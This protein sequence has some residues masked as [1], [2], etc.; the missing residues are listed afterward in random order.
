[1]ITD[2]ANNLFIGCGD[3]ME[4]IKTDRDNAP[5]LSVEYVSIFLKMA[6]K[7][8]LDPQ[9]LL[10]EAGIKKEILKEKEA[11]ITIS[12]YKSLIGNKKIFDYDPAF[13][14]HVGQNCD[15]VSH[16]ILGY[17]AISSPNLWTALHLI[18]KYFKIRNRMITSNF[19]INDQ[20]VVIKIESLLDLGSSYPFTIESILSTLYGGMS[21]LLGDKM[22]EVSIHVRYPEPSY[23][24]VYKEI[25]NTDVSFEQPC[26]QV[27]FSAQTL[28]QPFPMANSTLSKIAIQQ[29][30]AM[31]SSLADSKDLSAHIRQILLKT[32]ERF[33]S[34]DV[35]ANIL[36]MTPRTLRRQL[37]K[38]NTTYQ[39]I[40][41]KVRKELALQYLTT[42]NW[43][44]D[45]IAF[46]LDYC[47][48]SSFMRAF[49]KWT[50]IPPGRYRDD[51][52]TRHGVGLESQKA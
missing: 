13:A 11:F 14:L 52:V 1:M 5:A 23:S 2:Q 30:E 10:E 48:P 18:S 20:T 46:L 42:T 45:E 39:D 43:T 29:C 4:L 38:V 12:Q 16:G 49:K 51:L 3:G 36:H 19:Q 24:P 41:D 21:F 50:G 44:I 27:T 15:G 25:F 26:N 8:G 37:N 28:E 9:G 34:Q 7:M 6:E 31:L 33:P 17:V 22:P 35:L 32:P 47:E 40:M